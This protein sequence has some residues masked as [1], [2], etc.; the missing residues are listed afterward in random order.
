VYGDASHSAA[1]LSEKL[2]AAGV[3]AYNKAATADRA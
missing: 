2:D 1:N 3:E